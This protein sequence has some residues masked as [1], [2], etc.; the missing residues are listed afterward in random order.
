MP[1]HVTHFNRKPLAHGAQGRLQSVEARRLY[2]AEQQV[3]LG[4]QSGPLLVAPPDR[5]KSPVW[6]R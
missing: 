2:Q 4:R 5:T 1:S 6:D 3:Y